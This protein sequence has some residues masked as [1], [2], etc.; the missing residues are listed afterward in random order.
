[1]ARN[2]IIFHYDGPIATDHK[3]TLRTLGSTLNHLQSAIDRATIELR[4]GQV[5][6]HA[7]LR[8]DDYPFADF[9]VGEPQDG[10][11]ILNLINSG[12]LR[13]VDRITAAMDRA[14]R[15]A[16][17]ESLNF[18][19][20]LASQAERREIAVH[21][22]AQRPIAL[23]NSEVV[24][25]NPEARQLRY[26]D[27]AI[28]REIDQVLA[29]LRVDRYEGST[30]ELILAGTNTSPAYLFD[31]EK[32]QRFH[33]VVA[34]RTLGDPLL[35]EV[36]LRALDGGSKSRYP[37]GKAIHVE[38]GLTFGLHFRSSD[39]FNSVVGYMRSGDAPI[40][41]II[42]CPIIEYG[43][44]DSQAGDMFFIGLAK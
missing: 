19:E 16:S 1:M 25:Q 36:R 13:I 44:F 9:I 39:S 26:A 7:R 12:P 35:L 33:H 3:V 34:E 42:A 31:R 38:S 17:S 20:S 18:T 24:N 11:Y 37:V 21:A 2:R 32:A 4:H 8:T 23:S 30:L 29:Q 5:R 22:G 28:N 41:S 6:K 27:R 14:F 15:E 43:T 10:G 40:V